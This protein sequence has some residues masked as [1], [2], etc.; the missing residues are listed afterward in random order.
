MIIKCKECGHEISDSA[1]F[2]PSCGNILRQNKA[3]VASTKPIVVLLLLI[4]VAVVVFALYFF[5]NNSGIFTAKQENVEL[6]IEDDEE[7]FEAGIETDF[8]PH[9]INKLSFQ[10]GDESSCICTK[11]MPLE[12]GFYELS[13]TAPML[14]NSTAAGTYSATVSYVIKVG[15]KIRL[16]NCKRY[17]PL[18]TEIEITHLAPNKCWY[19][20]NF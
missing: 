2:C 15:D 5:L 1:E 11:V 8:F 10:S 7:F 9:G 13:F 12:N 18:P 17:I 16:Y 20:A 3:N 4:F 6:S 14:S 19:K